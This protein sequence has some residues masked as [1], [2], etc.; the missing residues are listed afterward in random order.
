LDPP[1]F[2]IRWE[3]HRKHI[4]AVSPTSWSSTDRN[5]TTVRLESN[6]TTPTPVDCIACNGDID[7][8]SCRTLW[9]TFPTLI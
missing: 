2:S 3:A 9:K 8:W 7:E 6:P 1:N 5:T 4:A